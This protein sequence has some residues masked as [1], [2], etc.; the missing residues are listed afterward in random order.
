[1]AQ[2]QAAIIV[3]DAPE[4][5]L[6]ERTYAIHF[7]VE[8]T[9]LATNYAVWLFPAEFGMDGTLTAAIDGAPV[10]TVCVLSSGADGS[11]VTVPTENQVGHGA[12]YEH[13]LPP[14]AEASAWPPGGG[15]IYAY[16]EGNAMQS[17][18]CKTVG[19]WQVCLL[20]RPNPPEWR[21][22]IFR[23]IDGKWVKVYDSGWQ[24]GQEPPEN[25]P[26]ESRTPPVDEGLATAWQLLSQF[27]RDFWDDLETANSFTQALADYFAE[28][29][30]TIPDSAAASSPAP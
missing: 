21:I 26:L 27:C 13:P 19:N 16:L 7:D 29:G 30:W 24:P 18:Y 14:P 11:S 1:L 6:D 15:G 17:C 8:E 9:G 10:Y 3:S 12:S 25:E 20:T 28:R 22:V 23:R 5:Q 2:Q 4:A